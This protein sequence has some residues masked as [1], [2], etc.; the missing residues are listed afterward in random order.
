MDVILLHGFGETSIIWQKFKKLLNS[1][2]NY[3]CP[4]F[5][6]INECITIEAYAFK[7]E[8]YITQKNISDFVLI[9]HSMGGYIALEYLNTFPTS[10][11]KGLGMFHSTAS[12]DSNVKKLQRNKTMKFITEFG[13][14]KFIESF[15]PNMFNTSFSDKVLIQNNS[16][17][18]QKIDPYALISASQAMR[19]RA[20]H[21][22]LLENLEIPIFYIVGQKDTFV[23][24]QDILIQTKKV[25]NLS[26]LQVSNIAHAGMYEAPK[27]CASFINEFL[28]DC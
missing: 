3:Y 16:I 28:K 26:L 24:S 20:D 2:N 19:D 15:Y 12:A 1:D 17:Q 13:S 25:K 10:N 22:I 14:A 7:L 5:S 9:G 18:F 23:N 6:G 11:V 27:L 4:D 21:N 8:E